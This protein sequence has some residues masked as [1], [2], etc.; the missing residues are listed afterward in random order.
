MYR[1]YKWIAMVLILGFV[2]AACTPAQA[3]TQPTQSAQATTQPTQSAQAT[4][5]TNQSNFAPPKPRNG[6]NFVVGYTSLDDPIY[7]TRAATD[8]EVKKGVTAVPGAVYLYCSGKANPV[9]QANCVDQFIGQNVD[10]IVI[11]PVD[12]VAIAS[13]IKEANAAGIPVMTI[14]GEIPPEAG[15]KVAFSVNVDDVYRGQESG[16]AMVAA[17]TKKYGTPKGTVLEITGLM[18][19]STSIDRSGGFHQIVDQYPDIKV[20]SKPGDFDTS[21]ATT[22][23]QDWFTANPDT[24]AIYL[25]TDCDYMPGVLSILTPMG[26]Y[27]PIG[28]PK[29]VIIVG[30]DACNVGVNALKCGYIEQLMDVALIGVG[31]LMGDMITRY[32]TT[33]VLPKVGDRIDEPDQSWEYALV[34]QPTTS[35][36]PLVAPVKLMITQANATDPRLWANAYQSEPNGKTA[37][38][39]AP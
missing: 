15:A 27:V 26:L 20:T 18:S 7:E 5:N 11:Y 8:A 4:T 6:K 1:F 24:D 39:K 21:K 13:Q 9:T 28:N 35:A 32:L 36:G 23:L 25:A 17:L 19:M 34:T 37:C 14:L 33:G 12:S 3:T 31:T 22:I 29:H 16:K 30:N 10:A 38:K 2:L